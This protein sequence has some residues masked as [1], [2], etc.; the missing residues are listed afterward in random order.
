MGRR[1]SFVY[2]VPQLHSLWASGASYDEIA[3]ALGC[4][5]SWVTKLKLKHALPNRKRT[6]AEST[7]DP[8]PDEI[9]ERAKECR[10][11]HYAKRRAETYTQVDSMLS[12]RRKRERV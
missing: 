3:A 8:T 9:A 10:E 5:S 11:K 7:T 1:K 4:C 2:S 6:Y 12:Q